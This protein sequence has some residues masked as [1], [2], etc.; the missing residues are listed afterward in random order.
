[1]TDKQD[2]YFL[3]M[4]QYCST[5]SKDPSTKTGAVIVAPNGSV[6]GTGYNGFPQGMS[7]ADENWNNREEKYSRV[8]HCEVNALI[9]AARAI[10]EGSTLYTYPFMSCDRCIVQ[11]L[12]AG[13][14]RFVAPTATKEQNERW[15]AAFARTREYILECGGELVEYY[16]H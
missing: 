8:V 6:V 2:L 5:A 1:M 11:M 7:D 13:I 12:Q 9:F 4:A 15:G 16:N 14:K 3:G 10:P